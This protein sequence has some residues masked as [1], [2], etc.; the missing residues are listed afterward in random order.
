[1]KNEKGQALIFVIATMT[2]ALALGVGVSL[3]NLSSIS[4]TTTTDTASRAQA[5]AEGGA[6]RVLAKTEVELGE[7]VEAGTEF[8]FPYSTGSVEEG[9]LV[10]SVANVTV[11]YYTILDGSDHLKL[12][13][14][15]GQ[16][17]EVKLAGG[18][19]IIEVCWRALEPVDIY[20][21]SYN[22]SLTPEFTRGGVT[23][24][25]IPAPYE[26]GGFENAELTTKD[27]FEY[28]F[29]PT[30]PSNAVGLRLRSING[31]SSLGIY[32][33]GTLPTQGY[34]ITSI[35]SVS[36]VEGEDDAETVVKV[37]RSLPFVPGVFDFG[38]FSG[39]SLAPLD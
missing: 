17:S 24:G 34:I 2:I 36:G 21:T 28:C 19:D 4:R 29:T 26:T 18:S 38:I 15:K 13:I 7:A 32:S 27:G 35:G 11:G 20:Y 5:A 9:N 8:E 37:T 33:D 1:M 22:D 14:N 16:V 31:D 23:T 3:R 10:T 6:E 30:L 39:S 25:L 12:D